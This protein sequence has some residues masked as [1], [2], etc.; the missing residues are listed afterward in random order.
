[1]ILWSDESDVLLTRSVRKR[2]RRA[3]EGV[4][5]RIAISGTTRVILFQVIR[6][7]DLKLI[8]EIGS[9]PGYFLHA[10]ETKGEAVIVKVFNTT[11]TVREVFK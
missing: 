3:Q 2:H 11:P 1:V 6:K 9:G 4:Q 5:V 8:L 10:G 7:E